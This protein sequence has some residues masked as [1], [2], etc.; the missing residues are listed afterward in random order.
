MSN[1]IPFENQEEPGF[2]FGGDNLGGPE[3]NESPEQS[4]FGQAQ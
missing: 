3:I 4:P 1:S 2:N